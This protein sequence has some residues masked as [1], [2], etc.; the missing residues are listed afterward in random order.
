MRL[1]QLLAAAVFGA[2]AAFAST[3]A[4][5]APALGQAVAPKADTLVQKVWGSHATCEYSQ[6]QGWHRHVGYYD[7]LVPCEPDRYNDSYGDAESSYDNPP[8]TYYRPTYRRQYSYY[9]R[10]YGFRQPS[11][12]NYRPAQ[13][14]R[15]NCHRDWHCVDNGNPLDGRRECFWRTLCN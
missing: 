1:R 8:T 15:Y 10:Y 11:R 14:S 7:R 3:G 6:R 12:Y 13:E 2:I 5:A 4:N 9:P